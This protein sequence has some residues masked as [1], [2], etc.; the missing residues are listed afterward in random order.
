MHREIYR[1]I[2]ARKPQ[3][4]H[5]LMDEHLR[6][7]QTAQGMEHPTERKLAASVQRSRQ[8]RLTPAAS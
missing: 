1:A 8:A 2:R 5:R 7:A 4:A 6:M 3:E